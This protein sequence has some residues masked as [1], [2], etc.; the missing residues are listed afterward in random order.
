MC[1]CV[2]VCEGVGRGP[3]L[4]GVEG[5]VLVCSGVPGL[6][7]GGWLPPHSRLPQCLLHCTC[8]K[9]LNHTPLARAVRLQPKTHTTLRR[10]P[11]PTLV[12][13]LN[14]NTG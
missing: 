1:L 13:H 8:L 6:S 5:L 4:W 3:L 12:T 14:P 9:A 10:S 2:C 7:F 11:P